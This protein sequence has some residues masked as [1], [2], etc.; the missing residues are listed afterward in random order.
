MKGKIQ[1]NRESSLIGNIQLHKCPGG[2]MHDISMTWKM[3]SN[4]AGSSSNFSSLSFIDFMK[5]KVFES[6]GIFPS[7]VKTMK[8]LSVQVK[9][10]TKTGL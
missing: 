8:Y 7:F 1:Q 3:K 5:I 9:F 6:I 4:R 2:Q 10:G